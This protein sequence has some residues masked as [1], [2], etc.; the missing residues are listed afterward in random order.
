M[1]KDFPCAFYQ[2]FSPELSCIFFLNSL[3]SISTF[4]VYIFFP[5]QIF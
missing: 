5:F 2:G 3:F 4:L 1:S